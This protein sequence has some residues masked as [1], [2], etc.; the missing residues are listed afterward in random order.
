MFRYPKISTDDGILGTSLATG[1]SGEG[2]SVS[3]SHTALKVAVKPRSHRRT[4]QIV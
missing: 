2:V 3:L 1:R 4:K